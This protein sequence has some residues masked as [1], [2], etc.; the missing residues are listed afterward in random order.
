MDRIDA[1]RVFVAALDEG[2]LAAAGRKLGRSPTA[3]TRAISA[4]EAHV[5]VPLL[6]RTTRS[7]RLSEA[8]ERYAAACRRVLTDLEEADLMAA[9]ERAAP[10]GLLAITAPLV[11]G[12][13][14]MRP[15]LDAFLDQQ[16][17]VKARLLLLDRSVNL[18]DEGIDVALRIGH[19]PDSSLIAVRIGEVRKLLVAAPAYLDAAAPVE[20][21]S[22]LVH[23]RCIQMTSFGNEGWIFSAAGGTTRNVTIEPRLI[24]NTVEAALGSALEGR[25]ITRAFSYQVADAVHMR[26]LRILLTK[27]EPLPLPV[28]LVMPEGRLSVPKVRAFVDHAVPLLRAEFARRLRLCLD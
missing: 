26:Q 24:V 25:G 11:S 15:I 22:D 27:D 12:S 16:P 28:H 5:G 17:A 2:S 13:Q 8:G 6:H 19:L 4:L 18:I 9:G 21:P 10:R 1:M 7:I 20:T 23:H 3:V 14:I